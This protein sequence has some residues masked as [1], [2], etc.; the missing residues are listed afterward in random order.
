MIKKKPSKQN[1]IVDKEVY[2]KP[3]SE[4]QHLNADKSYA[5]TYILTEDVA[6]A[7]EKLKED[8]GATKEE[9]EIIDEVMGEFNH[10]DKK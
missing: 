4:K 2:E 3:L 10:V 1:S 8:I 6:E 5:Y 9:I 7:V